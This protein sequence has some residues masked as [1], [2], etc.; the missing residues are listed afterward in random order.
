MDYTNLVETIRP[1]VLAAIGIINNPEISPEIRQLNQEI[2]L[3]EVGTAIYDKVYDMNAFDYEIEHTKGKGIDDRYYGLAKV[4]SNSI[5]NG[6]VGVEEYVDNYL[7]TMAA[8]AQQDSLRNAKQSRKFP[9]VTRT[10]S[11]DACKWCQSKVGTFTNPDSS[12]FERHG[13]CAGKIYTEGYK[14]RNGELHNYKKPEK[15]TVYRGEGTNFGEEQ[16][17]LFGAGRYVARDKATAARFGNVKAQKL[18]I[19]PKQIYTIS[20]DAQ[21]EALVRDAVRTFPGMDTQKSIPKLL[22]KRGFKA[23]EGTAAFDPLAG[24]S[25]LDDKLISDD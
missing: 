8:S 17:A 24:I 19:N 12:I 3:R 13:G 22:K 11:A 15:V 23:V 2:L 20:S 5:S 4:V 14:S 18:S 16:T 7:V 10:E 21:Y 9:R 25:V 1:Q 6:D